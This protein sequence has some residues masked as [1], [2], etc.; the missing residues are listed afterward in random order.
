MKEEI[1]KE[2]IEE[3]KLEIKNDDDD[4]D[5]DDDYDYDDG[6]VGYRGPCIRD[7][8]KHEVFFGEVVFPD[9]TIETIP[10]RECSSLF[11][12]MEEYV[13]EEEKIRARYRMSS[14]ALLG[15]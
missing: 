7:L 4:D 10:N 15:Y 12:L 13:L 1:A 9:E 6:V 3:I 2:R 11:D 8:C 14:L 5:D